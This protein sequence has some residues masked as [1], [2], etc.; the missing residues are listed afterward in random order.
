L[1]VPYQP[2]AIQARLS[3]VAD[4]GFGSTTLGMLVIVHTSCV[5]AALRN[6]QYSMI[7]DA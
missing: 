2:P 4:M 1:T 6:L 7:K 5:A 3:I